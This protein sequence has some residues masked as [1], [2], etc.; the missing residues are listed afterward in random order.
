[1]AGEGRAGGA[2]PGP[3]AGRSQS[4]AGAA[5]GVSG[6]AGGARFV[7][8]LRGWSGDCGVC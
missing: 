5:G 2:C 7:P 1:M 8:D 6:R 3:L 4:G